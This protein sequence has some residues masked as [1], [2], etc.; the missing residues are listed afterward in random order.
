M[1]LDLGLIFGDDFAD[2]C[3]LGIGSGDDCIGFCDL[4]YRFVVILQL[5]LIWDRFL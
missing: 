3:D 2:F 5:A 4:G 1:S